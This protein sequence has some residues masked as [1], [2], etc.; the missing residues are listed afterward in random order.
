MNLPDFLNRRRA[1]KTLAMRYSAERCCADD[2]MSA[3]EIQALNAAVNGLDA[4]QGLRF[5]VDSRSFLLEMLRE[6]ACSR[7]DEELERLMRADDMRGTVI[8]AHSLKSMSRTVGLVRLAECSARLQHAAERNSIS[9]VR[10]AASRTIKLFRKTAAQIKR[11]PDAEG[12][13]T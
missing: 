1:L 2:T 12:S 6:Y 13:S 11:L 9:G 4:A 3:Q 7:K 5:C 8:C 10:R